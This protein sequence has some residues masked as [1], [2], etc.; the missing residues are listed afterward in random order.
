MVATM[1]KR[2]KKQ[3]EPRRR[4]IASF[5]ATPEFG[6][7]LERLQDFVRMPTSTMLEAGVI[8]LAK[9]RG[10]KEPPPKR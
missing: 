9:A 2:P 5:K 8:E 7:W 3:T 1:A 6:A 10:F 4:T